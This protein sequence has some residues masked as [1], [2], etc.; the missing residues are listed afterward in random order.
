MKRSV[1]TLLLM[2]V[3]LMFAA[4]TALAQVEITYWT[5]EDPNRTALEEEIIDDEETVPSGELSGSG[6]SEAEA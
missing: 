1:R 6:G 4:S 2:F 3:A 5:H